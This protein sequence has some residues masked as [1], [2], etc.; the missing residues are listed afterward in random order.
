MD[1]ASGVADKDTSSIK[2]KEVSS[3]SKKA[4]NKRKSVAP[5][6]LEV[7]E[8]LMTFVESAEVGLLYH[9]IV[10]KFNTPIP[11]KEIIS[12]YKEF[13]K[14][15]LAEFERLV[16]HQRSGD[17]VHLQDCTPN[18]KLY[19]FLYKRYSL[20]PEKY[21]PFCCSQH[22]NSCKTLTFEVGFLIYLQCVYKELPTSNRELIYESEE[23]EG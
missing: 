15:E 7:E 5:T 22:G 18:K 4:A 10:S 23:D 21:T 13:L 1:F 20:T 14:E 3:Q 12:Y 9:E 11:Y 16:E 8:A 2:D 6:P 17:I 19:S